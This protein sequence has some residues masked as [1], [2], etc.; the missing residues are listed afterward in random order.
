MVSLLDVAANRHRWPRRGCRHAR[1]GV[2]A[3]CY[4]G[5]MLTRAQVA[6][7]LG[8]SIATVRR[9]EGEQLHPTRDAAGIHQFDAAEV[10]RLAAQVQLSRRRRTNDV[11][12]S[13]RAKPATCFAASLPSGSVESDSSAR[14]AQFEGSSLQ[15]TQLHS[16]AARLGDLE[17]RWSAHERARV[18]QESALQCASMAEEMFETL[19][20]LSARELRRMDPNMLDEIAECLDALAE[21]VPR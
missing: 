16:L 5:R 18:Q 2:R 9:L 7:R 14:S 1:A 15:A 11:H 17:E 4:A 20:S 19:A 21:H 10:E 6:R 8:K 3:R 13:P 12:G